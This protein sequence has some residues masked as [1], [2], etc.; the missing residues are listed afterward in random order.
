MISVPK[1]GRNSKWTFTE[2]E[3]LFTAAIVKSKAYIE[4]MALHGLFMN[5][6]DGNYGKW[7]SDV[8]LIPTQLTKKKTKSDHYGLVWIQ[9]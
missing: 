6:I 2:F 7:L 5:S 3:Q 4:W 1:I 9:A 8:A